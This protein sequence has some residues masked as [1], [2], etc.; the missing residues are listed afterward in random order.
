M[1]EH[2]PASTEGEASGGDASQ[3]QKPFTRP[4]AIVFDLC[5]GTGRI[6]AACEEGPLNRKLAA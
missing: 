3:P 4:G 5:M 1:L 2:G 6:V